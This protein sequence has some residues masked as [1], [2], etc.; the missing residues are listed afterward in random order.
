MLA[1]AAGRPKAYRAPGQNADCFAGFTDTLSDG[2]PLKKQ[3]SA[4][5]NT[6]INAGGIWK[7]PSFW[8]IIAAQFS[9][10]R[11]ASV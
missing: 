3:A 7:R 4:A 1:A 8:G 2:A 9:P 6:S 11:E 5:A 10:L